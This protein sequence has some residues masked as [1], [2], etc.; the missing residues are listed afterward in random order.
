MDAIVDDLRELLDVAAGEHDGAA[1]VLFGHSMGSI[2]SVGFAERYGDELAALILSGSPGANDAVLDLIAPMQSAVDAGM[3]DQ[4]VPA[5]DAFS[6]ESVPMRT[7]FDWLSRDEAEVDAYIADPMCGENIPMT[8]GF[9]AS[10]MNLSYRVMQADA[11]ASIPATLPVMLVTGEADVASV[12]GAGVRELEKRMREHGLDVDARYY[13]DARH[14]LL[15]EINRDDVTA[16]ILGWLDA[17][18]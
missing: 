11:V 10:L 15:N 14:E 1:V 8:F 9:I 2:L 3:G 12:N 4:P 7:K 5:F 6:D 17:H 13:P 18:V 16:D